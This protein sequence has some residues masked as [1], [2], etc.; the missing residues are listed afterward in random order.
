MWRTWKADLREMWETRRSWRFLS[1][2]LMIGNAIGAIATASFV[3]YV[4]SNMAAC[5]N[6]AC[7]AGV[8]QE[9][10]GVMFFLVL[11]IIFNVIVGILWIITEPKR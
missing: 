3:I 6:E 5:P 4:F 9:L 10:L 7:S 1:K 11:G 2:V 8:S